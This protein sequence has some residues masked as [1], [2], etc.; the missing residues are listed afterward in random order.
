MA[1]FQYDRDLRLERVNVYQI[2]IFFYAQSQEQ[3]NS[4][5]I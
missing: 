5:S 2:N 1:W 4:Q 3:Y